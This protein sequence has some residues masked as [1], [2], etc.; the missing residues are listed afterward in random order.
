MVD[1]YLK[2]T[3]YTEPKSSALLPDDDVHPH[4]SLGGFTRRRQAKMLAEVSAFE[5]EVMRAQ[6]IRTWTYSFDSSSEESIEYVQELAREKMNELVCAGFQPRISSW[7]PVKGHSF[8]FVV[9]R[10]EMRA[11]A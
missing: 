3:V 5:A 11:A 10:E 8:N 9:S 6:V 7:R 1:N 4:R 2:V